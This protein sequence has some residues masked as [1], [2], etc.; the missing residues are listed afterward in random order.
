MY[1]SLPHVPYNARMRVEFRIRYSFRDHSVLFL[2]V[3]V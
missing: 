1:Q 3:S 2:T